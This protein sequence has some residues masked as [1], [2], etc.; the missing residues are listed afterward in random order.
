MKIPNRLVLGLA[1]LMV[2][3]NSPAASTGMDPVKLLEI[4]KRMQKFVDEEVIS[5]SVT[6]VARHGE[7]ASLEAVGYSDLATKKPMRKDDLFWIASMTKPITST[8][9]LILQD[10]GKLSVD[11]PVE[12]YLPEFKGQWLIAEKTAN[13]ER[14]KRPERKVM[15]HDLLTHTSGLSDVTARRPDATLAEL[16]MGY[17]QTPLM[18][19]PGSK[20]QYSNQGMNT[21][22]RIVEVVSGQKYQDFLQ[23]R[24]FKPLGMKDT[25]FY[26][27]AGQIK[28]LA[29][30]YGPGANGHGL[31]ETELYHLG[32]ALL[33]S[34]TR[35]PIPAGGLFSTA[36]DLVRFY[37][38]MLNGG[39]YHGKRYVS[40]AAVKQM[41]SVQ[42]GDLKT[43]F[44]DGN[45]WGLGWCLVRQPQGVSAM[46]SPGTF[47]HGGAYGTQAWIDPRKDAIFLMLI[48]RAK[49]PNSDASDMRREF[50]DA[51]VKAIA[52]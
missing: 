49:L 6:L 15:L 19:A 20:W 36:Q 42:T 34:R 46:L 40:E 21:L 17:S 37:Q 26:P 14:L 18:F 22:G 7:I 29:K 3:F 27:T 28:R 2:A 38:M 24:L 16:A 52:E 44:T 51:A 41:T 1:L 50:Q 10:E 23:Q 5:G 30:S 12:K 8:A 39:T 33:A 9:I 43:G 13:E 4:P 45:A 32:G 11:D 35:T 48:Q 31:A 47:G 25:T